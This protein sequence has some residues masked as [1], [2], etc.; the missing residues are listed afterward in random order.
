MSE[1]PRRTTFEERM[2]SYLEPVDDKPTT[3]EEFQHKYWEVVHNVC[4]K[5]GRTS[6]TVEAEDLEQDV[7]VSMQEKDHWKKILDYEKSIPGVLKKQAERLATKERVDYMHFSGSYMYTPKD[8]RRILSESV[9]CE[10]EKAPD[11]EGRV[12]VRREFDKLVEAR[13]LAIYK[14]YGHGFDS[15][16]LTRSEQMAFYRGIDQITDR[17]NMAAKFYSYSYENSLSDELGVESDTPEIRRERRANQ[18]T[19]FLNGKD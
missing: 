12:D 7:W 17:L 6:A 11:I 9:W 5:I 19:N 16:E 18:A 14:R 10:A 2:A 13:R 4:K 1:T 8:V 3:F 15:F